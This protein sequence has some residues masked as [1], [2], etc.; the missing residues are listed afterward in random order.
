[1]IFSGDA[2]VPVSLAFNAIL[3]HVPC[4]GE[5]A[6]DFEE[7]PFCVFLTRIRRKPNRLANRE[8]MDGHRI[9][10]F[11]VRCRPGKGGVAPCVP[12]LLRSKRN[13]GRLALLA[14][15]HLVAELLA[16]M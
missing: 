9:S 6:N 15:L 10:Q 2:L 13:R 8:F 11:N 5:Q 4:F 3:E 16:L 12:A 7:P 1:M 14:A